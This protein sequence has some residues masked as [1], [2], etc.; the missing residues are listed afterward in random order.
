LA[1]GIAVWG[2]LLKNPEGRLAV[3]KPWPRGLLEGSTPPPPA[4]EDVKLILVPVP[5]PAGPPLCCT[6]LLK[7]VRVRDRGSDVPE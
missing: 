1:A 2:I 3:P 5:T 4:N 7:W 6:A